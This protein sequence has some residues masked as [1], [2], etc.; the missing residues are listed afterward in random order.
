MG[1]NSGLAGG[2]YFC[3]WSFL[4]A[5]AAAAWWH[6]PSTESCGGE[7][8]RQRKSRVVRDRA[9]PARDKNNL[10]SGGEKENLERARLRTKSATRLVAHPQHGILRGRGA[11]SGTML[12]WQSKYA[13]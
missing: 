8:R 9:H 6:T 5:F 2:E 11:S 10:T 7:A 4:A 3:S 13:H 12:I 1:S